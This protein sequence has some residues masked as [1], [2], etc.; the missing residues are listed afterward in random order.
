MLAAAEEVAARTLPRRGRVDMP[1]VNADAGSACV[2]VRA[3]V[4][5]EREKDRYDIYLCTYTC[6]QA[7]LYIRSYLYVHM[8]E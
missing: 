6:V 8:C 1:P 7:Y 2:C 5:R 4:L 3:C